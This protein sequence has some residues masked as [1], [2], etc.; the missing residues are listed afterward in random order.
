M[1]PTP[2]TPVRNSSN[3][4]S[5]PNSPLCVTP[6]NSQRFNRNESI[7]GI[8]S[9]LT[10][11]LSPDNSDILSRMSDVTYSY[12]NKSNGRKRSIKPL[13]IRKG[14]AAEYYKY[15]KQS[16]KEDTKKLQELKRQNQIE[17]FCDSVLALPKNSD[18]KDIKPLQ[19]EENF[20]FESKETQ[21][22]LFDD[23]V[24]EH[25]ILAS[26]QVEKAL[27][28]KQ[29]N[30]RVAVKVKEVANHNDSMS[31][32]F[33][34]SFDVGE[35]LENIE[36][37][38]EKQTENESLEKSAPEKSEKTSFHR[39]NSMPSTSRKG[40]SAIEEKSLTKHT[41]S[42]SVNSISSTSINSIS[43]ASSTG[44]LLTGKKFQVL[45]YSLLSHI[46]KLKVVVRF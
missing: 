14:L 20:K 41:S 39:F 46:S 27:S 6:L 1:S 34:E 8:N 32:F 4:T 37:I 2:R 36:N 25:L 28:P 45:F 26:Q 19:T 44:S 7:S 16:K 5:A 38:K 35:L 15:P 13:Q 31:G 24:N 11:S 23:S 40:A 33:D 3:A 10:D 9:P 12:G 43:S 18:D 29:E 22:D 17:E 30:N 42:S 21:D